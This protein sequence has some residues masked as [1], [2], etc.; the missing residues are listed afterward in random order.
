[1]HRTTE[2]RPINVAAVGVWTVPDRRGA[3]VYLV[4]GAG[5]VLFYGTIAAEYVLF[6]AGWLIWRLSRGVFRGID[7]AVDKCAPPVAARWHQWR[8]SRA[9]N[10]PTAQHRPALKEIGVV[11]WGY[12]HL[13]SRPDQG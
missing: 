8:D 6:A 3:A 2:T 5:Y 7:W 11:H 13:K 1:M 10:A 12:G 9:V 4:I